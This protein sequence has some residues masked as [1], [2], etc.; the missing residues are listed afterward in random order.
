M[1][2]LVRE[3]MN[4]VFKFLS[5]RKTISFTTTLNNIFAIFAALLSIISLLISDGLKKQ[6]VVLKEENIT[7]QETLN[8]IKIDEAKIE[9]EIF[10]ISAKNS[11]L[12]DKI[13]KMEIN[14]GKIDNS[15]KYI[16]SA[17]DYSSYSADELLKMADALIMN[18]DY[19]TAKVIYCSDKLKN[20]AIAMNNLGYMKLMDSYDPDE[21]FEILKNYFMKSTEYYQGQSN[22]LY[23]CFLSNVRSED[24]KQEA[25]KF[26]Q[27]GNENVCTFVHAVLTNEILDEVRT[28]DIDWRKWSEV[29]DD[30]LFEK[31]VI[32]YVKYSI[33]P[34]DNSVFFYEYDATQT[35]TNKDESAL[36]SIYRRC[37]WATRYY[38]LL[39]RGF[40]RVR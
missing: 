27:L 35:V 19:D 38:S 20:N 4:S 34:K 18:G 30:V 25:M 7:L 14:I 37:I 11:I 21:N 22:F 32:G 2:R 29:S 10:T 39:N 23:A 12:S 36:Y 16:N 28:E 8:Q 15:V 9:N 24:I 33:P 6:V 17:I 3:K 13:E 26:C 5:D 1:L 31:T 40:I